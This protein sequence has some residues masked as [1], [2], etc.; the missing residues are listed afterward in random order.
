MREEKHRMFFFKRSLLLVGLLLMV[1]VAACGSASTATTIGAN[2]TMSNYPTRQPT[3]PANMGGNMQG[4][5]AFIHI[6]KVT[7]NGKAVMVLTNAK[8][9][10]LYYKLNDPRPASACT[11]ACAQSWPPVLAKGMSM[12]PVP[13][14]F[15]TSWQ[16]I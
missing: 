5:T 7:L 4:N 11:G 15:H 2:N 3:Q 14:P 9:M 13:W 10:I 12:I 6:T 8:G 1:F 16:S